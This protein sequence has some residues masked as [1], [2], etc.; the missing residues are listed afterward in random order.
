MGGAGLLRCA[1]LAALSLRPARTAQDRENWIKL[2]P[3]ADHFLRRHSH[4]TALFKGR[5][6]L[7]GGRSA[8][9]YGYDTERTV[10]NADVWYSTTGAT[11]VQ[12]TDL[13]GDFRAQN[14]DALQPGKLAP[15]YPRFGHTLDAIDLDGDGG[16]D[17]MVMTGGYAP[18]P[19]NDVWATEDGRVWRHLGS[20]PWSPR[21]WH[22]AQVFRGKLH[23]FGG[24][25]LNN[26]AWR[27]DAIVAEDGGGW[28]MAWTQLPVSNAN[29]TA[30]PWMPRGGHQV[31]ARRY[32]KA[33]A[34]ADGDA[35]VDRA[36]G[37]DSSAR[38][39]S[40]GAVVEELFLVGGYGGYPE[41]DARH[42]GTACRRDVWRSTD[43]ARWTQLTAAAGWPGRA[44][45]GA[46]VWPRLDDPLR[47]AKAPPSAAPMAGAE[48]PPRI[49]I[50]GGG[51]LGT[52]KNRHIG[53][54]Q[55]YADG[56]WSDDGISWTKA[57][58][59][60]GRL[61][62]R[63]LHSTNEWSRTRY[64]GASD[65]L[66]VGKWGHTMLVAPRP[67]DEEP[68]AETSALFLIAGD[69][70]APGGL[71]SDVYVTGSG[72]QCTKNGVVCGNAG[73]CLGD[74][75]GCLCDAGY[76]GEFCEAPDEDAVGAATAL[77]APP[78]PFWA[79]AALA[80]A[81]HRAVAR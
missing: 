19:F 56:Y 59:E 53:T 72:V 50:M 54:V 42:D 33:E 39:D 80:V 17:L 48:R 25:P 29:A 32:R 46:A 6:W 74:S 21:A 58:R 35:P 23:I 43:G 18:E 45:F 67:S 28:S 81:L 27:C 55:A 60:E 73:R 71:A 2:A 65:E 11:W 63:T 9:Y 7:V 44:W 20:A 36:S 41:D 57:S 3:G 66:F 24:F 79:V 16:D 75:G 38:P 5:I 15:F 34:P 76:E 52:R 40:G 70:Q 47:D 8:P 22:A 14:W 62:Q 12:V 51:F 30:D 1:A 4:A 61:A 68:G 69:T 49:W 64:E 77:W 78:L 10:L 31:L 37:P 26:E 13:A